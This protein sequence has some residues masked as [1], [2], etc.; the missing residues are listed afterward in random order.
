MPLINRN[1]FE[2]DI[3]LPDSFLSEQTIF[4]RSRV[5]EANLKTASHIGSLLSKSLAVWLGVSL[6]LV[7]SSTCFKIKSRIELIYISLLC[8]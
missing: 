5:H 2:S 1:N 7:K 3:Y 4:M 8:K 6:V